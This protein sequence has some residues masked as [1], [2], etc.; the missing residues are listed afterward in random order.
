ML[1]C[2]QGTEWEITLKPLEARAAMVQEKENLQAQ[3]ENERKLQ[4]SWQKR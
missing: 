2:W 1:Q 4:Q 3:L